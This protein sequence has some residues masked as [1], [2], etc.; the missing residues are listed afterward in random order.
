MAFSSELSAVIGKRVTI[1]ESLFSFPPACLLF[2]SFW[3]VVILSFLH[4]IL[5]LLSSSLFL[6]QFVLA[7]SPFIDISMII[8]CMSSSRFLNKASAILGFLHSQNHD[9]HA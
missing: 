5:S 1:A 4:F 3:S 9:L 2:L 6:L 7:A 8:S